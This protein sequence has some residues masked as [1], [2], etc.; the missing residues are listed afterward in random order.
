MGNVKNLF[1]DSVHQFVVALL[2]SKN[3]DVCFSACGVLTNLTV[4]PKNRTLINEE[5]A[6]RR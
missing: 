2:D 5:G 3:P 6:V 1:C 4:D